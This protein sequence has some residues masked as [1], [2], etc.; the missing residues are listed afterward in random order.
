MTETLAHFSDLAKCYKGVDINSTSYNI[1]TFI[2]Y[3]IEET[4]KMF[5]EIMKVIEDKGNIFF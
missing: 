1:G 4:E 5:G 2:V 3:N